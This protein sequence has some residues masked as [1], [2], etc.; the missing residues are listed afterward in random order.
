VLGRIS[1]DP[2][3]ESADAGE[4]ARWRAIM[5][6]ECGGFLDALKR[7]TGIDPDK[8]PGKFWPAVGELAFNGFAPPGT[9]IKSPASIY[10]DPGWKKMCAEAE[11]KQAICLKRQYDMTGFTKPAK[12][13]VG[14]GSPGADTPQEPV[15]TSKSAPPFTTS[16]SGAFAECAALYGQVVNMCKANELMA[17]RTAARMPP[18]APP[19][20]VPPP[21]PPA[22][23]PKPTG[24]DSRMPPPQAAPGMSPQCQQLVSRY[25]GAAQANDGA[26]AVAG[27]NALK[28]AGGCG[29]LDKVGPVATAPAAGS[30]PRFGSRGAT[31]GIDGTVG[32]CNASPA[33]CQ[34]A[35]RQLEAGASAAAQAAMIS[36]AISV[37]LQLGGMMASGM[38]TAMPPGQ[39]G[40]GGVSGGGGTN[41]NS[42]GNRPV[43]RTY[44]EGSPG[45]KC[46][47]GGCVGR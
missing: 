9:P 18:P 29:V 6:S 10:A 34:R 27:Y 22:A 36:N 16:Q 30:D 12:S 43:S 23:A 35:M 45:V 24:G 20:P 7:R 32:A 1:G 15:V 41:M 2:L 37:G 4:R 5:R 8:D 28:A 44:G 19:K 26:G 47:P 46:P 42:I 11:D 25:V 13:T 17:L 40:G 14:P 31:P 3:L 39:S 33:E 21:T 38:M